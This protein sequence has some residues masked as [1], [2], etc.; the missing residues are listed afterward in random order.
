M[1]RADGTSGGER[2]EGGK[3]RRGESA[4]KSPFM[5]NWSCDQRYF[6]EKSSIL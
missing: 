2:R 6:K 5:C 4:I 3:A 1:Q